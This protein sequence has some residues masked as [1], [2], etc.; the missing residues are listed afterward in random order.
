MPYA[1][2]LVAR[3]FAREWRRKNLKAQRA[4]ERERK[5]KERALK[6]RSRE[7]RRAESLKQYGLT[8]E[9]YKV[10]LDSQG[11][12]CS[13]CGILP[14]VCVDHCHASGKIRSILCRKC[15]CGLGHFNDKPEL[16]QKAIDYLKVHAS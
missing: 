16:L 6:P 5:K 12:L 11:G 3:T 14:A 1:D 10:I 9:Q 2:K 13:I 8:E 7:Y 4:K 15:N